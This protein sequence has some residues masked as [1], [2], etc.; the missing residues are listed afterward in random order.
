MAG[1]LWKIVEN[2]ADGMLVLDEEG[3]IQFANPAARPMFGRNVVGTS[4]GLA[5]APSGS[6]QVDIVSPKGVQGKAEMRLTKLNWDGREASLASLRDVTEREQARRA[7]RKERDFFSAL[8]ENLGALVLILDGEKRVKRLNRACLLV[9]GLTTDDVVGKPLADVVPELGKHLSQDP[10]PTECETTWGGV[11]LA[12]RLT[13]F[14]EHLICTGYDISERVQASEL[15]EQRNSELEEARR[16]AEAGSRAKT[17]FLAMMSHELRTPMS[18]VLGM[19]E[20]LAEFP[21]QPKQK[22]YLRLADTG[23]KELLAILDDILDISKIEAGHITIKSEPFSLE[24][25]LKRLVGVLEMEAERHRTELSLD[26]PEELPDLVLGDWGRLRQVLLN[27]VGNALKFCDRKCGLIVRVTNQAGSTFRFEVWDDGDGVA[28]EDQARIF[29]PFE[30]ADASLSREHDGTGL[31]LAIAA[32]LVRRMGG[33]LSLKSRPKEG[34]IFFFELALEPAEEKEENLKTAGPAKQLRLLLVDD[35]PIGRRTASLMLG[36]WGHQVDTAKDG[37]S[38]LEWL[39]QGLN[40]LVLLDIQMPGM[41]GYEVL[42]ELRAHE[43]SQGREPLPVVA[44]TAHAVVGERERCLQAGMNGFL[45]KP[46]NRG[47]LNE[48]LLELFEE[49]A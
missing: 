35:N 49:E 15:L 29:Q 28:E 41:D 24:K 23:A 7:L 16:Q 20:L 25:A 36:N 43:R 44:L 38:A 14:D 8:M 2:S 13:D 32:S 42:R 40:D 26:Y 30:Q 4:L 10:L 22:K 34:S 21:M 37:P 1:D 9:S 33:E 18:A 11:T 17:D 31:G 27:L 45:S 6:V 12:W 46:I 19:L 47:Q 5:L 3:T 48:V 39:E